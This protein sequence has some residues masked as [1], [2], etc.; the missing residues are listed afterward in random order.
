MKTPVLAIRGSH[1]AVVDKDSVDRFVTEWPGARAL[2]IESCGHA[3][4]EERPDIINA[5]L[6]EFF[7]G[8]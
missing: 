4:Q 1:D 3:P 6:L 2:H 8:R 5:A 7:N